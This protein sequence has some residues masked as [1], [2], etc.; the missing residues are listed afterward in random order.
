MQALLFFQVNKM[1]KAGCVTQEKE[2]KRGRYPAPFFLG[3]CQF[4]DFINFFRRRT[5]SGF[6]GLGLTLFGLS[7]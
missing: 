3:L 7:I 5:I 4:I 2:G 1:R 6:V